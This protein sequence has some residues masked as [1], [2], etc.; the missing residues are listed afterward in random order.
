MMSNNSFTFCNLDST[1]SVDSTLPDSCCLLG[2]IFF[3]L[4]KLDVVSVSLGAASD[5]LCDTK[6]RSSSELDNDDWRLVLITSN[7][8]DS[9]RSEKTAT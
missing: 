2:F 4:K 1:F 7:I 3:D 9:I 6:L 5:R 8:N